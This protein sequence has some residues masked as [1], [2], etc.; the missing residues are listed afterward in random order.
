[1][2]SA[3][4]TGAPANVCADLVINEVQA[5]G[6]TAADEFVEIYNPGSQ[7][8]FG[9]WKLVYRAF[10]GTTDTVLFDLDVPVSTY[11]VVGGKDFANVVNLFK[12]GGLRDVGGQLALK[13]PSGAYVSTM[14]YGS[15]TGAWVKGTAAVKPPASQSVARKPDGTDTGDN[16]ADFQLATTPTPGRPN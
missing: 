9:T 16:G 15:A 6:A 3:S 14:G 4:S 5:D 2:S 7:C 8:Q 12:A 11:L 10:A 13:D 1:V